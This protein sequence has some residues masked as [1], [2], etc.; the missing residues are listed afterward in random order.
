MRA[1][2]A[3]FGAHTGDPSPPA[4]PEPAFDPARLDSVFRL[5][6]RQVEQGELPAAALAIGGSRGIVRAEAFGRA[7]DRRVGVGDRF[8]IASITKPILA[9]AVV[10]LVEEGRLTLA[11]PVRE[12]VPE[13]DP[14]PAPSGG[15]GG[16]AVT[17]WHLLTHTSGTLDI[18]PDLPIAHRM[19]EGLAEPPARETLIRLLGSTPLAFPPGAAYHYASDTFVILGEMVRRLRGTDTLGEA[20]GPTILAPL[21]MASTGFVP[22]VEEVASVP[23]RVTGMP[24]ADAMAFARAMAAVEHGG[25]GLWSTVG[26]LARFGRAMLLDGSL[27]GVRVLG[28]AWL[29]VMTREQ[30]LGILEP[31]APP[32]RPGYGLGWAVASRTQALPGSPRRFGHRGAS[33]SY[34]LVDPGVGLVIVLLG[35][36]W[37]APERL[38]DAVLGATY[39]ALE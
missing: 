6:A 16:E 22:E 20:I 7:G 29:D 11:Q 18:A 15:P 14:P 27:E 21:G 28:R 36:L 3:T 8:S 9:T 24:D 2:P 33:G 4:V 35:D 25:G 19:E 26:D 38:Q 39:G 34:L 5:V 30:T 12:I 17:T 37:G 32:R 31:G 23:P 10:Q 13:Y 1:M